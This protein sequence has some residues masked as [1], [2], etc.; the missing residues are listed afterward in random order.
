MQNIINDL[1]KL[2]KELE[3]SKTEKTKLET[4][5]KIYYDKLKNDFSLDSITSAN[6]EINDLD[7]KILDLQKQIETEYK[8]L[9]EKYDW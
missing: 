7:E 3:L 9:K 5:L 1:N 6:D 2:K 4:S 8:E